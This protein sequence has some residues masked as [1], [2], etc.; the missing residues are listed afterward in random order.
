[1]VGWAIVDN[2]AS[3]NIWRTSPLNNT[4]L[5]LESSANTTIALWVF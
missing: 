4:S 5:T 2:T 3:C 1:M